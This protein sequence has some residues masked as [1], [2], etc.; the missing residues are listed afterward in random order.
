MSPLETLFRLEIEFHQRL[1]TQAPGDGDAASLHTSYA[2]QSGYNPLLHSLG[3]V[4][5]T[6]SKPWPT[7]SPWPGI[8]ATCWPPATHSS[9]S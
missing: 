9:I 5:P 7:A 1:R 8:P 4:T 2:L 6:T 3:P